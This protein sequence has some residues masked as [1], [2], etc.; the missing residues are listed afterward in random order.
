MFFRGIIAAMFQALQNRIWDDSWVILGVLVAIAALVVGVAVVGSAH[1]MDIAESIGE[2]IRQ[3]ELERE[4]ALEALPFVVFAL[5]VLAVLYFAPTCVACH[6]RHNN[7]VPIFL[8]NLLTGWMYGIGWVVALV[9]ACSGNTRTKTDAAQAVKI[10]RATYGAPEPVNDNK[11]VSCQMCGRQ[12]S[13]EA[14]DCPGCGH[15]NGPKE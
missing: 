9:W 4:R 5:L 6:R 12:I 13:P 1:A 11:L 2:I 15:P 7:A 8:V 14:K 10:A 3:Q